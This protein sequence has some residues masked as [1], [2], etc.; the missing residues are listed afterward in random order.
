MGFP[1]WKA[2]F[3]ELGIISVILQTN[4]PLRGETLWFVKIKSIH[5]LMMSLIPHGTE[6][7]NATP[8]S[9]KTQKPKK[10]AVPPPLAHKH[11]QCLDKGGG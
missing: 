4:L 2:A 3:V 5:S 6:S 11:Q 9:K 7:I 8:Q 10:V 1:D